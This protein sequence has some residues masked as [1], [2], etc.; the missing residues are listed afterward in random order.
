[1]PT[2][3]IIE[4]HVVALEKRL[5]ALERR[6][7]TFEKM[8]VRA[9]GNT[10]K[11]LAGIEAKLKQLEDRKQDKKD[12]AAVAQKLQAGLVKQQMDAVKQQIVLDKQQAKNNV[13]DA[14]L[15]QLEAMV[16]QALTLAAAKR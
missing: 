11:D 1:M 8:M 15:A 3:D 10:P 2:P 7:D 5:N 16:K 13:V 9:A 12:E 6:F 14:R 4:L